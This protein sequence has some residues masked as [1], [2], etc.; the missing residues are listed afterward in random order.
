MA[1]SGIAACRQCLH[2][3][4][5]DCRAA[6]AFLWPSSAGF[7]RATSPQPVFRYNFG[8]RGASCNCDARDTTCQQR[9][10]HHEA[11]RFCI[12]E[13]WLSESIFEFSACRIHQRRRG[14]LGQIG[15]RQ[16]RR[17]GSLFGS[18]LFRQYLCVGAAAALFALPA[19]I[20]RADEG[21]ASF[22]LPG[23][24]G[25]LAAVPQ[26]APGL[27]VTSIYYH[28][29]VSA[30]ADVARAREIE[31]GRFPANLTANVSASLNANL[32]LG[33]L[34]GTYT[35]ATPVLGGQAS[36]SL[37]GIYGSNS[38]SLAGSLVGTLAVPALAQ[39][40][41]HASTIST[42]RSRHLAICTQ[43]SS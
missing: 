14:D 26:E 2:R 38:T 43:R 15:D 11:C 27:S 17:I 39:S 41:S 21:G 34:A 3:R 13:R 16:M 24:F 4:A 5:H 33:F 30:G 31:I 40:P 36:A 20:A 8:R 12:D 29:S 32:D 28:D 10:R 42:A 9:R 35:F 7:G 23:F 18:K 1:L 25:S 22:W 37:L 6:D 19:H